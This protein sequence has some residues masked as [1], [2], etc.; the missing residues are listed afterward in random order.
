MHDRSIARNFARISENLYGLLGCQFR[1]AAWAIRLAVRP[2]SSEACG[3]S[4]RHPTRKTCLENRH[5][6]RSLAACAAG[7]MALAGDPS[8]YVWSVRSPRGSTL[9]PWGYY[10]LAKPPIFASVAN[11]RRG[12]EL[13]WAHSYAAPLAEQAIEISMQ[14][15]RAACRSSHTATGS[16]L[17]ARAHYCSRVFSYFLRYSRERRA[18][19]RPPVWDGSAH[20]IS[21][22]VLEKK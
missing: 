9:T 14:A 5:I 11:S 1:L 17:S 7:P 21:H 3:G 19:Y 6:V 13:F 4:R 2:Q 15:L 20:A 12:Y 10:S 18:V 22:L 8:P 16:T